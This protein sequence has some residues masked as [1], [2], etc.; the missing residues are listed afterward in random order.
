MNLPP[1]DAAIDRLRL[2]RTEGVGPV[3]YRRLLARYADAA[4]ALDALPALA[5]AGGRATPPRI[6][7]P[8]DA[9]RE[10]DGI[11]ALGGRLVFQGDAL[12]PPL[13]A[14][15]EDAPPVLAVLGHAALLAARAVAV[16]GS[17]NASANGQRLAE[18]LAADLAAAGVVVVSGLARGIDAAAHRGALRTGATIACIAGGPDIAYPPEHRALQDAIAEGGAVVAEHAPGTAPQARHFPRRNRVIAGLA[19]GVVVVEAAPRSGSLITAR[20]ANESGR[21]VFAVPGSPLDPRSRGANGLIRDGAHLTETAQDVLDALPRDAT[22][23]RGRLGLSEAQQAALTPGE[24][25][26]MTQ[27]QH[28]RVIDAVV[29][30][31]GPA[32]T[33]VDDLIRRCQFSGPAVLSVLLDLEIAGRIETLPGNRVALLGC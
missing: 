25:P 10:L 6:P 32:P 29:S 33:A 17:R 8:D 20:L 12:Y 23:L 21:E 15:L 11:A 9:R 28:A 24:A 31:L 19:L 2:A 22:R 5:R 18:S 27:D 16:V 14:Q 26:A 1:A 4:A 3:A 30:L 13:L 7:A